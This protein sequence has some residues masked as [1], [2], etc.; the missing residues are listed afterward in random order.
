MIGTFTL[1]NLKTLT[2]LAV[3]GCNGDACTDTFDVESWSGPE[4][5]EECQAFVRDE[6]F[7]PSDYAAANATFEYYKVSCDQ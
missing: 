5:Y 4:S 6:N 1:A 7:D 3:A 2:F